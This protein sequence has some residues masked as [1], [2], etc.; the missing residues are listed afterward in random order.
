MDLLSFN[1]HLL[2]HLPNKA[3]NY[4]FPT[5]LYSESLKSS[6]NQSMANQ[7]MN[8]ESAK[9]NLSK[10]FRF[11]PTLTENMVP[12]NENHHI[13]HPANAESLKTAQSQF[14]NELIPN[15]ENQRSQTELNKLNKIRLFQQ[16]NSSQQQ[17][18]PH[19]TSDERL[20]SVLEQCFTRSIK[21]T[22][23]NRPLSDY[24]IETLLNLKNHS[25]SASIDQPLNLTMKLENLL[26]TSLQ[27]PLNFN[28]FLPLYSNQMDQ[29][30]STSLQT[31][32]H[33]L[34]LNSNNLLN[35]MQLLNLTKK[36]S[37]S[38]I[39][40]S[41]SLSPTSS[42]SGPLS[43]FVNKN[44][45]SGLNSTNA[46]KLENSLNQNQNGSE[47]NESVNSGFNL[48][49]SFNMLS[50]PDIKTIAALK[51]FLKTRQ[52]N[53]ADFFNNNHQQAFSNPQSTNQEDVKLSSLGL[54]KPILDHHNGNSCRKFKCDQ[55]GKS[56]KRSSTLTTHLL[57]HS[58]TRPYPC[59][60]CNKS[61]LCIY[62]KLLCD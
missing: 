35:E 30:T 3:A 51:Q 22:N 54:K 9:Q 13:Q 11:S 37:S 50:T 2:G 14:S 38:P 39:S 7:S 16:T 57:I 31:N 60:Y 34:L 12:S 43:V 44:G 47:L 62:D 23:N 45:Y 24:S 6:I 42:N 1:H 10:L 27:N 52:C 28:A 32:Y 58:N 5:N 56:Y 36:S 20:T 21:M 4:C 59:P 17:P 55:C 49:D 46:I 53:E 61:K 48:L 15:L 19:Q 33:Q 26:S 40:S 41:P 29:Q 18:P 25:T 8:D